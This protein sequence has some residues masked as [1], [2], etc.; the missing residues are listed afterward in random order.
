[1]VILKKYFFLRQ[2]MKKRKLLNRKAEGRLT[3]IASLWRPDSY[4]DFNLPACL[5]RQ[6]QY[7]RKRWSHNG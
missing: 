7:Y 1:V 3:D 6:A 4:L 2:G 5:G